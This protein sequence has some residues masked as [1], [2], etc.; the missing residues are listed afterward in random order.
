[1]IGAVDTFEYRPYYTDY[2][3]I[4]EEGGT[5]TYR[6]YPDNGK[7][8]IPSGEEPYMRY[9]NVSASCE[10]AVRRICEEA[11]FSGTEEVIV[12]Q[13]VSYFYEN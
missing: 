11:G 7:T 5:Y 12:R 3:N 4:E 1:M 2:C 9:L 8:A 10:T 13:I 6:Y